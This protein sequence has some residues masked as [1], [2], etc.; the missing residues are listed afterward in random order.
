MWRWLKLT[1]VTCVVRYALR[2]AETDTARTHWAVA[3]HNRNR[4][5]P[6]SGFDFIFFFQFQHRLRAPSPARAS[7]LELSPITTFGETTGAIRGVDAW[8]LRIFAAAA[9][10][11]QPKFSLLFVSVSPALSP[12]T[13]RQSTRNARERRA[14]APY[15]DGGS[16]SCGEALELSPG[17]RRERP[18]YTVQQQQHCSYTRCLRLV[19]P[20]PLFNFLQRRLRAPYPVR[21]SSLALPP[22]IT[23]SDAH[24]C[25]ERTLCMTPTSPRPSTASFTRFI[26]VVWR[27]ISVARAVVIQ[28]QLPRCNLQHAHPQVRISG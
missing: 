24:N 2:L 6:L 19:P 25:Q 18:V 23:V 27:V 20:L 26:C 15:V 7:S 12:P 16:R 22:I 9:Q 28:L 8:C 4:C 21:A 5:T 17:G 3:G 1:S 13:P 11:Q 10:P 14:S